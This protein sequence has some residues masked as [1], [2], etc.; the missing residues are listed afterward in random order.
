MR[1]RDLMGLR[2]SEL[3]RAAA[4]LQRA[5]SAEVDAKTL[6]KARRMN[7]AVSRKSSISIVAAL[8]LP[9]NVSLIYAT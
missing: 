7:G 1:R 4:H 8:G 5:F 6:V 9:F 2:L 3:S